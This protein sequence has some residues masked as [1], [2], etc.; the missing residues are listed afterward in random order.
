MTEES[1]SMQGSVYPIHTAGLE[2]ALLPSAALSPA[3]RDPR[4]K[5]F[6]ARSNL[7]TPPVSPALLQL[8][9]CVGMA[10]AAAAW[11][12]FLV[13]LAHLLLAAVHNQQ[14]ELGLGLDSTI[15]GAKYCVAS[16]LIAAVGLPQWVMSA[17]KLQ[18]QR[19]AWN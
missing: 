18:A 1:I 6:A 2:P 12:V 14:G 5:D 3:L 13:G 8:Q 10:L 4:V 17:R 15:S 19:M 11:L 9:K 7:R 16:F